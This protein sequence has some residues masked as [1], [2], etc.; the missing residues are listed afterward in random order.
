MMVRTK[1]RLTATVDG[2]CYVLSSPYCG[3]SGCG[4]DLRPSPC[5]AAARTSRACIAPGSMCTSPVA[6]TTPAAKARPRTTASDGPVSP[7]HRRLAI[8]RKTPAHTRANTI[9]SAS[10]GLTIALAGDSRTCGI[11]AVKLPSRRQSTIGAAPLKRAVARPPARV[12]LGRICMCGLP[13]SLAPAR[14]AWAPAAGAP[15]LDRWSSSSV[16]MFVRGA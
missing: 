8:G 10:M 7:E 11:L 9:I 4:C 6:N 1:F 13:Q 5:P 3:C 14:F 15:L 16:S 12:P 2:V